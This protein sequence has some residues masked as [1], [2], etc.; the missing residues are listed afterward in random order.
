MPCSRWTRLSCFP[1]EAHKSREECSR[2]GQCWALLLE[3]LPFCLSTRLKFIFILKAAAQREASPFRMREEIFSVFRTNSS[4]LRAGRGLRGCLI[5]APQ[6]GPS[7]P[8]PDR[9]LA[10]TVMPNC[11]SSPV[12]SGS[13]GKWERTCSGLLLIFLLLDISSRTFHCYFKLY[14]FTSKL[15]HPEI[16]LSRQTVFWTV[17]YV[18]G[19]PASQVFLCSSVAICVC[20]VVFEQPFGQMIAFICSNEYLLI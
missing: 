14:V 4:P 2:V 18:V 11:S 15:T 8:Y 17:M 12:F 3:L 1:Q 20:A 7:T 19:L 5:L 9:L 10:G 16:S 13:C 6:C